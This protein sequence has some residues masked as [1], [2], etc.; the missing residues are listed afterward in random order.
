MAL[1]DSDQTRV[2]PRVPRPTRAIQTVHNAP[3]GANSV[4]RAVTNRTAAAK[5]LIEK[6]ADRFP[7]CFAVYEK[8]R[9][10]LKIGIHDD[11]VAA[12][13]GTVSLRELKAALAL[14]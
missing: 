14:V 1:N 8:R 4:S 9:R 10:P 12:L 13:D 5:A 6:L 7:A 2:Y 11:L 3:I